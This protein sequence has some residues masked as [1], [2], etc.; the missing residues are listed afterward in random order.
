MVL[1]PMTS[2]DLQ[3]NNYSNFS[4]V[5]AVTG[6]K[7]YVTLFLAAA[8]CHNHK[9][10]GSRR[11]FY[12]GNNYNTSVT[13]AARVCGRGDTKFRSWHWRAI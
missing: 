6:R 8:R 5:G 2:S 11:S 3:S 4:E 7:H 9:F 10:H 1:F 12:G 13:V